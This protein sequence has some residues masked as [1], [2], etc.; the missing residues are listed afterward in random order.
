VNTVSI[1]TKDRNSFLEITRDISGI[2][3][4]NGW[5]DGILLVYTPHTTAGITINENADPDVQA[6]MNS[7]LDKLVPVSSEFKH[8]EGNSDSHIKSSLIG[9]SETVIVEGGHLVLGKWQGIYLCDFDGPRMRKVFL[10]FIG[11]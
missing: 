4:Q 10:K 7:F 5:Q 11:A 8:Y 9:C 6:D 2:I 3:H 1:R